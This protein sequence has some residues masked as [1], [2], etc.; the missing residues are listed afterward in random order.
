MTTIRVAPMALGLLLFFAPAT[1]TSAGLFDDYI[2]SINQGIGDLTAARDNAERDLGAKGTIL[3]ERE[4]LAAKLKSEIDKQISDKRS[5]IERLKGEQEKLEETEKQQARQLKEADASYMAG[6]RKDRKRSFWDKLW[7]GFTSAEVKNYED[8]EKKLD[9]SGVKKKAQEAAMTEHRAALTNLEASLPKPADL[10]KEQADLLE[11]KKNYIAAKD[12]LPKTD[13]KRFEFMLEK[14]QA[15][16]ETQKDQVYDAKLLFSDLKNLELKGR[17]NDLQ[18][19]AMK[20]ALGV[21]LNNTLIGHYVNEQIK[22]AMK[23]MCQMVT[24]GKCGANVPPDLN[25]IMKALDAPNAP[26]KEFDEKGDIKKV[27]PPEKPQSPRP[28]LPS[29]TEQRQSI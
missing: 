26:S 21:R 7:N 24:D 4:D 9:E 22:K 5:E 16:F 19:A 23:Q 20:D 18:I 17:I 14:A 12:K 15:M 11:A 25:D 13:Q 2:K 1:Q 27:V 8:L 28:A 3:K 10:A 29:N 6:L